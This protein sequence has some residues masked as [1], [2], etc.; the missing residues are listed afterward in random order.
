VIIG[1]AGTLVE[2]IGGQLAQ[3]Q[4]RQWQRQ[5]V[6]RLLLHDPDRVPTPVD[7]THPQ[8]HDVTGPQSRR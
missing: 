3:Q 7:I 4:G 1:G 5:R 6:A 2:H 8:R